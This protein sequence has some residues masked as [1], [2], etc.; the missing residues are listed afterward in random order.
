INHALATQGLATR[1]GPEL[2]RWIGLRALFDAVAA[3]AGD[4]LAEDKAATIG[5]ALA[6]L[7]TGDAVMVGDRSFDVAGAH[8][9]GLPAIGVMWGIGDA[10]ELRAAGA[11]LLVDTPAQLPGAVARCAGGG[12]A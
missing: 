11:E 12:P 8:A 6:A 1:P 7:G 5:A 9:H 4:A 10:A 2:D 3:P